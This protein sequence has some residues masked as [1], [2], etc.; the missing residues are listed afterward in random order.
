MSTN[1]SFHN[2]FSRTAS[3]FKHMLWRS[4]HFAFRIPH[5]NE[6][7]F[8]RRIGLAALTFYLLWPPRASATLPV[9]DHRLFDR[10]SSTC[11]CTTYLSFFSSLRVRF[12]IR[13]PLFIP[14]CVCAVYP[15]VALSF[16]FLYL[17]WTLEE[18]HVYV[19]SN[20]PV[21]VYLGW[22][23][24]GL[25]KRKALSS[26]TLEDSVISLYLGHGCFSIVW[27]RKRDFGIT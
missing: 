20:L 14:L 16:P 6:I 23:R 4:K 26:L 9:L 21:L 22:A 24:L 17:D 3:G 15:W 18:V 8:A 19:K 25:A 7:T 11:R 5:I 2:L 10:I 27:P 12:S 1:L 13:F